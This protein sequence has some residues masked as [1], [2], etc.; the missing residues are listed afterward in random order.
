[1]HLR[2]LY[3]TP[4]A[5]SALGM[6]TVAFIVLRHR[7]VRGGR[8]LFFLC[9]AAAWWSITEGLLY[10]GFGK[11]INILITKI[12][13]IGITALPSLALMMVFVIF[14]LSSRSTRTAGYLLLTIALFIVLEVWLNDYHW[15]HFTGYYV[16]QHEGLPMLG[17]TRGPIWYAVIGYHYLI[18]LATTITI[19]RRLRSPIRIYRGQARALLASLLVVW[20]A[21]GIY[22]AGLSP[23]KNMDIGPIAFSIVAASFAWGFMKFN[24]FDIIPAAKEEIFSS[25]RDPIIILDH[26]TRIVE[27]NSAASELFTSKSGDAVGNDIHDL[28][29]ALPSPA[30]PAAEN[31]VIEIAVD[32]ERR[33]MHFEVK[34]SELKERRGREIGKVLVL[35]D[36]TERKLLEN[37]LKQIASTDS[38]TGASN[39][40]HLFEL[41]ERDFYRA[42]RYGH[43]LC[44]VMIDIDRFKRL[45]DKHGHDVG[46]DALKRLVNTCKKE[47]RTADI[48]GRIGGEEFV[49]V[50]TD[51]NLEQA[52]Q[53]A[54]RLREQ[55]AGIAIPSPLGTIHITASFGVAELKEEDASFDDLLRRADT[56]LYA[57]K[58]AGRNCVK[59]AT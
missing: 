2:F 13:Y 28:L 22:V 37:K 51:Q 12:Q 59:T 5:I 30:T 39:R 50:Y 3:I 1:M 49:T 40:R 56:A 55:I 33:T 47:I 4:F 41:A 27:L 31:E 14:G 26:N 18:L 7:K 58:N 38:L 45:N 6:L 35:H 15:M 46:D 11:E 21:N 53:A 8:L 29:P 52:R 32:M 48:F 34:I 17:L 36:I 19:V 25:L 9:L 44:V 43:S 16:I 57:A 10:F 42:K 24:L 20:I 23:L 54:D